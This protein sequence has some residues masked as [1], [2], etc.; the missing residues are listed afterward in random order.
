MRRFAGWLIGA[1]LFLP[2]VLSESGLVRA[3]SP[4]QEAT[5]VVSDITVDSTLVEQTTRQY[6]AA[7]ETYRDSVEKYLIAQQTYYQLNTLA[8]QD[9]AIRRGKDVM[10]ARAELLRI[11]L[12][13]LH[14]SVLQIRGAELV[15]KERVLNLVAGLLSQLTTYQEQIPGLDTR[16]AIND[17]LVLLNDAKGTF[18]TTAYASLEIV[19]IGQLQTAIDTANLLQKDLATMVETA[20]ISAADRAIKQR[21]LQEADRL[22]QNAADSLNVA[23]VKYRQLVD[24]GS[25]TDQNYR[26][27]QSEVEPVYLEL[28]QADS[29]L[30]ETAKGL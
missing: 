12:T 30:Q 3:Q 18:L 28:R 29:F 1:F 13:Y 6:F 4:T 26:S 7:V 23:L 14:L 25:L 21:G 22:L 17:H 2:L 11:Y 15:D 19:K 20:Q 8:A 16:A 9:E 10:T 24:R 27:F 5:P